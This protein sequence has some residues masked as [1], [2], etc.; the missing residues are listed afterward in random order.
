MGGTKF[1]DFAQRFGLGGGER[2]RSEG[3][4]FGSSIGSGPLGGGVV[5]GGRACPFGGGAG[6]ADP[7][8]VPAALVRSP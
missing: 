7:E 4:G 5:D 2:L 1:F 8:T 6:T 3:D